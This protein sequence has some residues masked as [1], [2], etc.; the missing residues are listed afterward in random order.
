MLNLGQM[1]NSYIHM[2]G[3]IRINKWVEASWQGGFD[4]GL[5]M[6]KRSSTWIDSLQ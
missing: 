3:L 2:D 4:S 5:K 6:A 1:H